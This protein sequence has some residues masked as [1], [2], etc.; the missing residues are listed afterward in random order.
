MKQA[1]SRR[2]VIAD[3]NDDM[4]VVLRSLLESLGAEVP[5]PPMAEIWPS[6]WQRTTGRSIF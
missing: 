3:D 5:R 4:R 6:S 2:V 1:T